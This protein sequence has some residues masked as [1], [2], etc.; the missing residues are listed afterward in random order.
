[1]DLIF[2]DFKDEIKGRIYLISDTDRQLD[3]Y[4]TNNSH[5]YRKKAL[6]CKRLLQNEGEVILID[7][8]SNKVSPP[9][10]IEHSLNGRIF[11]KTLLSFRSNYL[12]NLDFLEENIDIPSNVLSANALDLRSS[13]R[14]KLEA[15][16]N[17]EGVKYKFAIK[18]CEILEDFKDCTVPSWINELRQYFED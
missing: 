3:T 16:F 5:E 1:M 13:E 17:T 11:Y 10:E 7:I 12:E 14:Q 15:F 4:Q 18:Y 8:H 2:D 9:T 6:Q